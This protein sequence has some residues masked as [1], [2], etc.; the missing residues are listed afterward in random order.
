MNAQQLIN[1]LTSLRKDE[2]TAELLRAALL[3]ALHVPDLTNLQTDEQLERQLQELEWQMRA[4]LDQHAAVADEL[5]GLAATSPC[6]FNAEH[7][8]TLVRAIKVQ[9]QILN[10]YLASATPPCAST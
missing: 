9:N 4:A 7:L 1:R 6:D 2:D 3:I 5:D 8:W 10:M